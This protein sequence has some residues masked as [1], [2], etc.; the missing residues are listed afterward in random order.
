MS[1]IN[2]NV[3]GQSHTIEVDPQM[4]LLW[5]LR[6]FI[7]L[8]GTKFGCG[9][10]QCGACTIHLD[11]KAVQSCVLP[12]STVADKNI[13][14]IEGISENNEHPVQKAW[15]EEQVP[16]CGYCHSGQIMAAV[17]LF[18]RNPNPGEDEIDAAM[19]GVICRCGTYPRI[20]KAIQNVALNPESS[21]ILAVSPKQK[22]P[23]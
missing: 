12:V 5:V 15:I 17:A 2:L 10:G 13:R 6:D 16:Q 22:V 14:T 1:K 8:T 20:K 21:S 7:G 23:K 3:N 4:P 18:E 9:I 11:G 19:E